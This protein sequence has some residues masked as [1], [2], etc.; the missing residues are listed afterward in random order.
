MITFLIVYFLLGILYYLK[1]NRET[2]FNPFL[3]MEGDWI[4]IAVWPMIMMVI[5]FQNKNNK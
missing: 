5:F 3:G 2:G 1:L 4:I